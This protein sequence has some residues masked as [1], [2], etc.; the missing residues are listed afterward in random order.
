MRC[1][2][3]SG[4]SEQDVVRLMDGFNIRELVGRTLPWE[5]PCALCAPKC[6]LSATISF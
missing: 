5:W 2:K 6:P 1:A 3:P 4:A